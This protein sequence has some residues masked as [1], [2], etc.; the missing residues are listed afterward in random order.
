MERRK[1]I[2][3][4]G[5]GTGMVIV[6]PGLYFV[7]PGVKAYAELILKKELFYLKMEP[8]GL[9]QY[10]EDYFAATG[11][12]LLSTI[13][14]K[15]LYFMNAGWEKSDRISDLMKYYLLSSDFFIHKMDESKEVHYL[16][17]FNSYKS[18]MPNPYSFIL[19]PPETIPA[20]PK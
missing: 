14:W 15:M 9:K 11:N 12:N 13:K 1:F 19:Y 3:L 20:P 17:L 5:V 18:P 4:V 16:G 8:K 2:R 10:I 7:A 6:P